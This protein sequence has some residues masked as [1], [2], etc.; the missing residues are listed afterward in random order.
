MY[1]HHVRYFRVRSPGHICLRAAGQ[2]VWYSRLWSLDHVIPHGRP[3][4]LRVVGITAVLCLYEYDAEVDGRR[5]TLSLLLVLA[6]VSA[7]VLRCKFS[8]ICPVGSV[9]VAILI[10]SAILTFE[11]SGI[12]YLACRW[13]VGVSAQAR[14]QDEDFQLC[15]LL[16]RRRGLP[17]HAACRHST[18][19]ALPPCP[20][21]PLRLLPSEIWVPAHQ[22]TNSAL[23]FT[24]S[25]T[26]S[27]FLFHTRIRLWGTSK[28]KCE[29]KNVKKLTNLYKN[30]TK[31][32]LFL[33]KFVNFVMVHLRACCRCSWI[34]KTL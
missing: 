26:V 21:A 6:G 31:N 2:Y 9:V 30:K 25:Q 18:A 32:V 29:I 17:P 28:T 4:G 20:Y 11:A 10:A 5:N 13:V 34:A 24:Q 12:R 19:P 14:R 8:G 3:A 7:A 15:A 1:Q 33:F 27:F 23:Q 22:N 16:Q